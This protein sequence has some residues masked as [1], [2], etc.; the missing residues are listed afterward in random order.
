MTRFIS[1]YFILPLLACSFASAQGTN[2]R[3]NPY[4]Y[5]PDFNP[6]TVLN[7]PPNGN[8]TTTPD[9]STVVPADANTTEV[10]IVAVEPP[11]SPKDV[12]Y[13]ANVFYGNWHKISTTSLPYTV[14]DVPWELVGSVTYG[15]M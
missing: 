14:E 10:T 2:E 15:F 7:D 12:P 1:R 3:Y 9:N 4:S 6:V 13:I 5:L 8:S 11:P